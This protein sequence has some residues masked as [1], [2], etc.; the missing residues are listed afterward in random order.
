MSESLQKQI[1][2]DCDPRHAFEVFTAQLDGW[3]PSSHRRFGASRLEIEPRVG[4]RFSEV[5]EDGERAELGEVVRWEPPH[6]VTYTWNPGSSTGPTEV[7]VTFAA[8]GE[9]TLVCVTHREGQT[10]QWQER[11]AKFKTSWDVVLP[12]YGEYIRTQ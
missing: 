1:L 12:A 4:G 11:V 6:R 3:W 5:S 8:K 7:D 10:R 2:V 9:Q